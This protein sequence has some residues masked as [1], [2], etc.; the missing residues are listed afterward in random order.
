ME[1]GI[2]NLFPA[3]AEVKDVIVFTLVELL[4]VIAIIASLLA[5][6]MPSLRNARE[7]TYKITCAGNLRQTYQGFLNYSA[8]NKDYLPPCS[9]TGTELIWVVS[10]YPS[11][12]P[13]KSTTYGSKPW[14]NTAFHCPRQKT[15]E[16]SDD[17]STT[18]GQN[19][20][21]GITP[22][23]LPLDTPTLIFKIQSPSQTM[24]VRESTRWHAYDNNGTVISRH[25]DSK[26]ILF[27][28]GHIGAYK[29]GV[30]W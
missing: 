1:I 30:S 22:Y 23:Q 4:V 24:M 13:N 28:D 14:R 15:T 17:A 25:L 11:I 10:I 20:S 2:R 19:S 21:Y 16:L 9:W 26:N 8:D 7:A 12:Y 6:L 3:R 5:M 29:K 27:F 18:G